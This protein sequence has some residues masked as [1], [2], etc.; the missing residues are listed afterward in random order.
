ML[1]DEV[2]ADRSPIADDIIEE[3]AR[4]AFVAAGF[5]Q[6]AVENS[7]PAGAVRVV[8]SE[9]DKSSI[10]STRWVRL[11]LS[12]RS[13]PTFSAMSSQKAWIPKI[14]CPP[15][16][17]SSRPRIEPTPAMAGATVSRRLRLRESASRR[18]SARS[19]PSAPKSQ[20]GRRW[21]PRHAQAHRVLL[22][23]GVV[24]QP[25]TPGPLSDWRTLPPSSQTTARARRS[26][27]PHPLGGGA[28]KIQGTSRQRSSSDEKRSRRRGSAA[29]GESR[30]QGS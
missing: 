14:S 1:T 25:P 5:L 17:R 15:G 7:L 9:R 18:R 26:R 6:I 23:D 22:Q 27:Q 13:S 10:S 16:F 28:S 12:S 29:H 19:T 30:R 8:A 24:P 4:R 2:N 20:R 3:E 11:V 21:R